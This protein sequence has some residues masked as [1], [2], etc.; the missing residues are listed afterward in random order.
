MVYRIIHECTGIFALL[1]FLSLVFAYPTS[2]YH[3]MQGVLLGLPSFYLY[4]ALRLVILGVIAHFEP[5]L[6]EL[7]HQYMMVLVNLGFLL[8][9]WLNWIDQVVHRE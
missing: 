1:I 5:D 6:V 4:S 7:F 2:F 3:K 9:L 8:F